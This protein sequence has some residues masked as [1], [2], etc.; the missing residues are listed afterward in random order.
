MNGEVLRLVD[1]IHRDKHIDREVVFSGIEQALLSALHKHFG[2]EGEVTVTIDR[3]N[4]EVKALENGSP[5]EPVALGRIAA[6]AAK[7]I[8][9]QKI[10]EAEAEVIYA[11]YQDR[12]GTIVNGTVQRFE[13]P[14]MIVNLGRTE[15]VLPR[16][17]QMPTETYQPGERLRALVV[18]VKKVGS[19]VRITLSRTHP[20][21]IRRLF[22]L[23][24]PEIRD[25]TVE[26]NG[27]AREAGYRTKIA[28][29]SNDPKVDCMGACVGV[30]GSRVRNV[31][32][33]LSGEKI[34]II[35]Y[36]E[37]PDVYI[38]YCL[39]PA[40]VEQLSLDEEQRRAVVV[41]PQDQLSLAIG[42][43]GQNV[44]LASKLTG[45]DIDIVAAEELALSREASLAELA[46]V[47][48]LTEA[49]AEALLVLGIPSARQLLS[50]S[51]AE[52]AGKLEVDEASAQAVLDYVKEHLPEGEE[53]L[54]AFEAF[55]E[56]ALAQAEESDLA[57]SEE[58]QEETE[59]SAQSEED[60][61]E[62]DVSPQSDE[63]VA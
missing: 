23:E 61:A 13:G 57:E 36:S 54:P 20:D 45:W 52:L 10:R 12:V 24:V 14:Y 60:T 4:G 32:D 56:Q 25:G 39:K 29:S 19:K 35:R 31:M 58:L 27:L 9:I 22:E 37:K 41:V 8:I 59:V 21:F 17:E 34:D 3:E 30:R 6:Q 46:T 1:S 53:H 40:E 62:E 28:V 49:Q 2:S 16:F 15:A 50:F 18:D 48:G 7:Q 33:E 55:L 51:V 44:R 26:V 11:D 43:R 47:P 5:I 63:N 38:S 42:K